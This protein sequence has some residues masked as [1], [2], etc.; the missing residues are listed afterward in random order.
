MP[1]PMDPKVAE[2]PA[3]AEPAVAELP[4]LPQKGR[5][6]V[7]CK[8]LECRKRAM[9]VPPGRKGHP[10]ACACLDCRHARIAG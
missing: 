5:H 3:V 6:P 8:C 1:K 4:T 9:A 10:G 7:A 2:T